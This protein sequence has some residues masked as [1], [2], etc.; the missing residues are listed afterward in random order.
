M[1][2][3]Y[4]QV[5]LCVTLAV[6]AALFLVAGSNASSG[7]NQKTPPDAPTALPT[8]NPIPL[9]TPITLTIPILGIVANIEQVGFTPQ[10]QM[11]TPKNF[12]NVAWFTETV[13]P[14]EKGTAVIAGHL[15]TPTSAPAVFYQLQTL[16]K[17]DMF[18]IAYDNG[19][20]KMFTVT[21]TLTEPISDNLAQALFDQ[22]NTTKVKV[23][24][25]TCA[26]KWDFKNGNY[27]D[28]HVV[29]A[30]LKE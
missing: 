16:K 18:S 19:I 28:R 14:G 15:D 9:G 10:G 1:L 29:F 23:N 3:I 22:F 24:L 25:V 5:L 4:A 13:K 27:T 2:K 17:G 20:T 8:P 11:D 6:F 7:I 26:G 30:E 21:G 12:Y